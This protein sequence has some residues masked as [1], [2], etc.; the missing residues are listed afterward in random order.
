MELRE[1]WVKYGL[2]KA[3]AMRNTVL[4]ADDNAFIRTALYEIFERE[5]DFHVCAVVEN[6]REAIQEASRLQPDLIVLDLAMPVMNGL[7]AARALRQMMPNVPIIIYSSSPNEVSKQAV[8]SIGISGLISKS[9]RV[10][11]LIE[12][13]R[14]AL[15][16]EAA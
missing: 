5:P 1:R 11:V 8:L 6:G 10:S 14:G 12:A 7:D 4:I 16:R 9:D 13:V 15:H 3:T 2:Q